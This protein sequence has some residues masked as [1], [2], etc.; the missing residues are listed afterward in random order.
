MLP[1]YLPKTMPEWM[2]RAI[3]KFNEYIRRYRLKLAA[4]ETE[5]QA[6]TVVFSSV[7]ATIRNKGARVTH[8]HFSLK[9]REKQSS[10]LEQ[11]IKN[12]DERLEKLCLE[13]PDNIMT[14]T[15][16]LPFLSDNCTDII[17]PARNDAT[18]LAVEND[19][20]ELKSKVLGINL[21][22][23]NTIFK[24]S[25]LK[26]SEQFKQQ[27]NYCTTP[28]QTAQKTTATHKIT[29]PAPSTI[30]HDVSPPTLTPITQI[31]GS[32]ENKSSQNTTKKKTTEDNNNPKPHKLSAR[33]P[34]NEKKEVTENLQEV[35]NT[36]KKIKKTKEKPQKTSPEEELKE[37]LPKDKPQKA[38]VRENLKR[39]LSTQE[40]GIENKKPKTDEKPSP[41]RKNRTY[42]TLSLSQRMSMIDK[43]KRES[44]Y[45]SR[46]LTPLEEQ[47]RA[48]LYSRVEDGEQKFKC[49]KCPYAHD[50]IWN[51]Q[52]HV[53]TVHMKL[54]R[55]HCTNSECTF[56]AT[57]N[58]Q[59]IKHYI[60]R[61]TTH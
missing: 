16:N 15:R 17:V 31:S 55:Y 5:F 38:L 30:T 48:Q 57:N 25:Q 46:K 37:K 29:T 1:M 61:H 54:H 8:G 27:K 21:I 13:N 28:T 42:M 22:P 44:C 14:N 11:D 35:T 52:R 18:L 49:E 34:L 12:M 24:S 19:V 9:N 45:Q 36:V 58:N 7:M 4:V 32:R 26:V 39:K 6:L 3:K 51:I 47:T 53:E 20:K 43:K 10:L 50:T 23:K 60:L 41:R 33:A 59:V 40:T 56:G 2:A